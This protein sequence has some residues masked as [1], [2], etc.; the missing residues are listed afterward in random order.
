MDAVAVKYDRRFLHWNQ[1]PWTMQLSEAKFS[2][3]YTFGS[4]GGIATDGCPAGVTA[5]VEEPRAVTA[6]RNLAT[7]ES[8]STGSPSSSIA[9]WKRPSHF[10]PLGRPFNR[11]VHALPSLFLALFRLGNSDG[12]ERVPKVAGTSNRAPRLKP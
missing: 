3:E 9:V 11:L 7:A 6:S 5:D 10:F 1:I 2:P 4:S 12:P 8:Q